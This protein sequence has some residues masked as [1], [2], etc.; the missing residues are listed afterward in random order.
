MDGE[1]DEGDGGEPR[2]AASRGRRAC[3]GAGWSRAPGGCSPGIASSCVHFVTSRA[4]DPTGC[5]RVQSCNTIVPDLRLWHPP[6]A[7][8]FPAAR[9]S[10]GRRHPPGYSEPER[11]DRLSL[12]PHRPVR[13]PPQAVQK[14]G[15]GLVRQGAGEL[16]AP[17]VT[18][19]NISGSSMSSLRR[20]PERP[21]SM[22]GKRR[23]CGQAAVDEH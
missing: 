3:S 18:Y 14:G 11:A 8:R 10:V 7:C 20:V 13:H 17:S 23:R 15:Q 1:C 6:G 12:L 21:M 22:D 16:A 19:W 2:D 4:L 5:R 9:A